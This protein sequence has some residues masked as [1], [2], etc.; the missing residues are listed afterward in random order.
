MNVKIN[1]LLTLCLVTLMYVTFKIKSK[2]DEVYFQ[3]NETRH[4]IKEESNNF[5]ILKTEMIFLTSHQNIK[6]MTAEHL[7]L[8]NLQSSNF[9]KEENEKKEIFSLVKNKQGVNGEKTKVKWKYKKPIH[10]R[11][12][13]ISS[14]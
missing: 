14:D 12:H 7:A 10:K 5:H 4:Q 13:E 6:K 1:I 8:T 11:I 3:L 2:T 9:E